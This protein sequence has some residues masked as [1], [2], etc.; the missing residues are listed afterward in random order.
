MRKK[1]SELFDQKAIRNDPRTTDFATKFEQL[2]FSVPRVTDR[3]DPKITEIRDR[4][5][6]IK[7][8]GAKVKNR[9]ID[10]LVQAAF[11]VDQNRLV[12]KKL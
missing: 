8:L 4:V 11:R 12:T 3:R 5:A 1:V 7:R 9:E 6:H 2:G 10:R